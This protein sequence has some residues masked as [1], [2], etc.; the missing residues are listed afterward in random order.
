MNALKEFPAYPGLEILST[1]VVLVDRK[2]Y[3]VYINPAAEHLFDTSR[4]SA[5]GSALKKLFENPSAVLIGVEHAKKY[6]CTYI[7]HEIPLVINNQKRLELSYTISPVEDGGDQI[8][9]IEFASPSQQ[10]KIAR[11]QRIISETSHS[12][13]LIRNLAHEIK[14][15]L[16]ALRGAAQLLDREL[17]TEEHHEYTSVTVS[18]TH[19][20]AHET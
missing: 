20:R 17:V 9:L 14:N 4:K 6:A 2:N 10:T 15:P 16:G 18:Y 5:T 19:L 12:R 13:E 7:Q 11:E 1:A 3:I 8:F